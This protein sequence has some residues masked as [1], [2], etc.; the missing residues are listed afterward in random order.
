MV[1]LGINK[2]L[3]Q[4][5]MQELSLILLPYKSVINKDILSQRNVKDRD[6]LP[7]DTPS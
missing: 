2:L 6:I 1:A 5:K 7:L 3:L 4:N